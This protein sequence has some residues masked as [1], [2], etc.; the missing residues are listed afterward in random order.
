MNLQLYKFHWDCGRM[1][2]LEGLI[3][4]TPEEIKS[5]LGKH[6][7][8]G[9]VLGKHSEICGDVEEKDFTKINID[10]ETVLKLYNAVDNRTLSGYS[11]FDFVD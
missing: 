10:S 4:A 5:I 8:F 9:E 1:G 3:F 11:P 6:V 2:D 7:Y